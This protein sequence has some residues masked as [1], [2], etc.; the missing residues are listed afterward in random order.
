MPASE[1]SPDY[2]RRAERTQLRVGGRSERKFRVG[3]R[4]ASSVGSTREAVKVGERSG[5]S[6]GS[7][8]EGNLLFDGRA[9]Q[10]KVVVGEQSEPNYRS[11]GEAS[12][13]WRRQ[14]KQAPLRIDKRSKPSVESVSESQPNAVCLLLAVCLFLTCFLIR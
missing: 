12:V 4:S 5:P 7:A 11:A 2:N 9:K 13:V 14:A 8:T 3:D 6:S 10:T 1:A